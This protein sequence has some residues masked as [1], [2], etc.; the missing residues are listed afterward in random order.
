VQL[1]L[2]NSVFQRTWFALEKEERHTVLQSCVRLASLDWEH[3]YR[4][5]G[6][7]WELIHSRR[8][9]DGSRLYSIRMTKRMRA[10]AQCDGEF[11]VFFSLHPDHDSAY[12]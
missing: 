11:L 12:H 7:R 2:N 10:V 4:D 5:R 6:F 1:D 9:A 3:L 8:A